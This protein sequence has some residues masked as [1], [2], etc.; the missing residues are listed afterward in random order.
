MITMI[1]ILGFVADEYTIIESKDEAPFEI[2][3]FSNQ[4][5]NVI[6]MNMGLPT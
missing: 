1:E 5:V 2:D 4:E 6:M 3:S